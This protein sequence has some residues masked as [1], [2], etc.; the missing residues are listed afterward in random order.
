VE[1][2]LVHYQF[3]AIHPFMDG[4]GR[5][6]RLL[7][8]LTIADWC[9]LSNQ[10]LYMS[11]YFDRHRDEYIDL[12]FRVS[13]HGAWSDWIAF[14]L[15]GVAEQATDTLRRCDRLIAIHGQFHEKVKEAKLSVRLASI[16]DDLFVHPVVAVTSVRDRFAVSYPTAR[17][18]LIVLE[19][20]GV[21]TP[22]RRAAQITYYSPEIFAVIYSD[23]EGM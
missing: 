5:V 6:G 16:V 13:T 12:L 23:D 9:G 18:D 4:N 17:S 19:R 11:A 1:A 10:W 22:L 3:E 21:L 15:R 20:L 2:F 8:S 7:L 14:C